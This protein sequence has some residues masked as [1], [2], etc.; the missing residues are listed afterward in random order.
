LFKSG[1]KINI[2]RQFF[3]GFLFLGLVNAIIKADHVS[4]LAEN[5]LFFFVSVESF[6]CR[7]YLR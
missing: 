4:C 2:R 6:S 3:W 7:N 1:D 5:S